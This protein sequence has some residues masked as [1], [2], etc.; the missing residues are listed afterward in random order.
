MTPAL[1]GRGCKR[2]NY[3]DDM[4]ILAKGGIYAEV[5]GALEREWT[6]LEAWGERKGICFDG[7]KAEV[8]VFPL[9]REDTFKY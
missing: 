2:F 9:R 5:E 4:G 6:D 3:A 8:V 1:E 7:S